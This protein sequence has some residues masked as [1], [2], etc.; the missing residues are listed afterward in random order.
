MLELRYA[1][2]PGCLK[3]AQTILRRVGYTC[4]Q[5]YRV[6]FHSDHREDKIYQYRPDYLKEFNGAILYNPDTQHWLD[7][8][9]D[10]KIT[11]ALQVDNEANKKKTY[12]LVS[13]LGKGA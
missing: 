7:F 5:N 11:L 12:S 9:S 13:A 3:S 10:D 4:P 2:C 8:Y 1:G 6:E